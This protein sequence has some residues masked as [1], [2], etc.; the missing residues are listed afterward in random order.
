MGNSGNFCILLCNAFRCVNHYNYNIC[1]FYS[2]YSTDHTEA[3]NF[4]FYFCFPAKSGCI[5]K[6]IIFFVPGNLRINCITSGS[7]NIRNDYTVFPQ[8]LIDQR[9]LT[10]IRFT[11]NSNLR[12]IGILILSHILRE[13]LYNLVQHISKSLTVSCRNGKWLADSQ[14]IKFINIHHIFLNAVHLI[15]CKY[16]WFAAAAKHIC[17]FRIRIH[18]SLM[19]IC[20]KDND[21]CSI[22]SDLSLLPH[23]RK[24]HIAAI[25]F[26]TTC[27]NNSKIIIQP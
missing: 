18:K 1:T 10:N 5:D 13:M 12:N 7:G 8:Q 26:N 6:N 17:N 20:N 22:N 23:L 11:Y 9:G 4:F 14:I 21:I 24:N 25:R 3:L 2:C 19:Y 16:H 27:V 15:H